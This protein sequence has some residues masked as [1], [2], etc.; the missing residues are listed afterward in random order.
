[1][2]FQLLVLA[3]AG[4]SFFFAIAAVLP[5]GWSLYFGDGQSTLWGLLIATSSLA[6]LVLMLVVGRNRPILQ[7]REAFVLVSF[8]WVACSLMGALPFYAGLNLS[9]ADAFFES[10]SGY[11]TTG[12]TVLSGLDD[13]PPSILFF[14][15]ETQWLGG[16]GVIVSAIALMPFLGVGGMQLMKAETPGPMKDE[17]LT[18]R[19]T[20]AAHKL[21]GLYLS[22]TG[23]CALLFWL[24]GMSFFDA[25]SHSFSTVSTGGYSTHDASVA[26]FQSPVIEL[27]AVAFML[28]GGI[29]FGV[30]FIAL[31]RFDLREYY[32]VSE[33]RV[34]LALVAVSTVLVA[35]VL[36]D[37]GTR[38]EP[39]EAFRYALFEVVS[40]ITSTGF[41]IDDFSL[42]PSVLPLWIILLGIVGGCSASTAGGIKVVRL[43]LLAKVTGNELLRLVHPRLV[44]PVKLNGRVIPE[45]VMGAIWA[46]FGI[47]V[48]SYGVSMLLL[49]YTGMDHVTAFGA[50]AACINNLGPGLGDVA[51][52]FMTATDGQKFLMSAVMLLGRLE[53]FTMLVILLPAFWR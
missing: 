35:L 50:V 11:T 47:Y 17:K 13:M 40:V 21:W 42:W 29:S 34:F 43:M 4:V 2:Q 22:M 1:M 30:H 15:Q 41:A 16:I 20:Q 8:L 53:I 18:P 12:A 44:K 37:E 27:I 32:R 46:F 6:T 48:A 26:Y 19:V 10:V 39:F 45:N 9:P 51:V 14:R 25:I 23:V 38:A 5:L 28:L 52:T 49:M 31:R 36:M 24:G 3:V 33:V 7:H